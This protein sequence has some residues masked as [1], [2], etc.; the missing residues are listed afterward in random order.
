MFQ[1]YV[2]FYP[3]KIFQI[4]SPE[5]VHTRIKLVSDLLFVLPNIRR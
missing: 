5:K 3:K 2:A 1:S 4:I